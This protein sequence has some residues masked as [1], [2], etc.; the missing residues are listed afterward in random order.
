MKKLL[1]STSALL[2][3]L[4]AFSQQYVWTQKT[5]PPVASGHYDAASFTING[6]IYMAGGCNTTLVSAY[7]DLWEY[8]P[9]ND[10]WMQKANMPGNGTYGSNSFVINDEGYV[11]NGW[12]RSGGGA[13]PT[14]FN[15]KYNPNTNLWTAITPFPV[16]NRYTAISFAING[17]GYCG[18]GYA[19]LSDDFWEYNPINGAWTQMANVPGGLRQAAL[20]ITLGNYGYAGIGGQY[21]NQQT[22][23]HQYDPAT[24]TWAQKA[25]YTGP[26]RSAASVFEINGK[27]YIVGGSNYNTTPFQDVYEYNGVNDAWSYV[28]IFPGGPRFCMSEGQANNCGYVGQ[29]CYTTQATGNYSTT[30][31][32]WEYGPTTQGISDAENE[33]VFALSPNPASDYIT[34]KTGNTPVT[35]LMLFDVTGKLVMENLSVVNDEIIDIR[36]LAAGKYVVQVQAG[37]KYVSEILM[38]K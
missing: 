22:D 30:N 9:I 23:W 15:N 37:N 29:G 18:T 35:K 10:S 25:T 12:G 31:D 36:N 27:A 21:S 1:L 2:I 20:A 34:I 8:D 28:G 33:S 7:N 14:T 3:A 13:Y 5:A 26:A 32:W 11:M 17:K 19:P 24:N 16:G 4:A 6:K 38:K